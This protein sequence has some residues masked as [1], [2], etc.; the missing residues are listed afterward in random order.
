MR[1]L[2]IFVLAVVVI[3]T[4]ADPIAYDYEMNLPETTVSN[5]PDQ[6]SDQNSSN[7]SSENKHV[8]Y[9]RRVTPLPGSQ[10]T[11]ING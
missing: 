1:L 4:L 10:K 8:F 9:K 6:N 3:G 7:D 5:Q 2:A 11:N